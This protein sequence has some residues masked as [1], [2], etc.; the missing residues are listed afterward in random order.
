VSDRKYD[1][2]H[3]VYVGDRGWAIGGHRPDC[4]TQPGNP[5]SY[6]C[7]T[8]ANVRDYARNYPELQVITDG[9]YRIRYW[10]SDEEPGG[11][12]EIERMG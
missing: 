5:A 4:P 6:N 8:Y 11:G 1:T 2:W 7:L 12:F 10:H 3:N 9:A